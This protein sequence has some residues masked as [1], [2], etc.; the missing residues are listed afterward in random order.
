M[1]NQVQVWDKFV[2]VFHWLLVL[3]FCVA[4]V[5]GDD[6]NTLHQYLGYALLCLVLARIVW[7][8]LGTQ[9]ALFKNFICS[10]LKALSYIKGLVTGNP[11]Y[12]IGHNPAAAWMIISLLA[13]SIIVCISGYGAISTEDQNDSTKHGSNFSIIKV[14]YADDDSKERHTGQTDRKG[15][16]DDSKMEENGDDSV[17]GEIH[18]I[19]AQF[20]LILVC[21]HILGVLLS[22][23]V[24]NENLTKSMITGTKSLHG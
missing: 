9:Y 18:E 19:T 20:M 17:W 16:H 21:F 12:H 3:L 11:T 22:S 5:T 13:C 1:D 4:Y 10:P 15:K 14:A 2:R 6:N 24:H 23:K 7:G 8:F